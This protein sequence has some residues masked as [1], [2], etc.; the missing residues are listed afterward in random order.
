VKIVQ[1]ESEKWPGTV[2]IYEP[3]TI[4][5]E[6]AWEYA[7]SDFSKALKRGGGTSAGDSALLPGILACVQEWKLA[8]FPE[9]VS[10]ATF[11]SKPR[12]ERHKLIMWLAEQISIV[13]GA[14]DDPNA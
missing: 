3:L 14:S 1:Y 2:G 7:L 11:P 10:P 5:Q 4:D 9:R 13:Y 6:A 8:D 12:A